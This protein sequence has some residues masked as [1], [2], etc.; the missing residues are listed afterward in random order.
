[1]MK[2]IVFA[3]ALTV[4]ASTAY[5]ATVD[6]TTY[7]GFTENPG[8]G[9]A[10]TDPVF[11]ASFNSPSDGFTLDFNNQVATVG[12]TVSPYDANTSFGATLTGYLDA[13][14]TGS[15]TVT[16][17]SDDAGYLFINNALVVSRPGLNG[18]GTNDASVDLTAGVHPFTIEYYNGPPTGAAV[19]LGLSSGLTVTGVPEPSTWALLILGFAGL[20]WAGYRRARPSATVLAAG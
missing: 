7:N 14:A 18:Y 13:S 15:Y 17:G 8:V 10:F 9:I 4:L 16:L 6:V 11:N 1:M 2:K 20:G 3:A 19:G 12:A 5:G